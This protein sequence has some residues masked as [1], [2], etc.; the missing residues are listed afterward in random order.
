MHS[1]PRRNKGKGDERP[2]IPPCWWVR[3]ST[4]THEDGRIDK[5]PVRH[6]ACDLSIRGHYAGRHQ[7]LSR[8]SPRLICTRAR[9]VE[10][11]EIRLSGVLALDPS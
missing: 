9:A 8:L 6:P 3:D 5:P 7:L 2:M 4:C 1:A 10:H 11:E